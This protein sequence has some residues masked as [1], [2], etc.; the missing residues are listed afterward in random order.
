MG[1]VYIEGARVY[2]HT[3]AIYFGSMAF[4]S[5]LVIVSAFRMREQ[6]TALGP[7]IISSAVFPLMT[8]CG[9]APLD[10]RYATAGT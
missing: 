5:M 4:C 1:V 7:D 8:M 10:S 2:C 9:S 3:I 6:P